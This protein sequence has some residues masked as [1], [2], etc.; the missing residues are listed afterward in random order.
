[1]K[2]GQR[3]EDALLYAV[4]LHATQERKGSG[5]PYSAHLL[6]TASIALEYG[7]DE[8][9]AV[10]ALLHDA[11]ED[12]GGPEQLETIRCKFGERVAGIVEGCTD[13]WQEPKPAWRPRKK[14]YLQS[15]AQ[16]DEDTL[17]VSCADKLYNARAILKDYRQVGE[18][19][20]GRFNAGKEGVLWYYRSLSEQYLK[21]F[22]G[23][24]AEELNNTV[25]AI[26]KI[27]T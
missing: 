13:S 25:N 4:H 1:M 10:A 23:P 27:V 6:G 9:Q 17:L 8:E 2:L 7:A 22:P 16:K 3:F 5:V 26:E 19:L 24:L 14:A 21:Y 12:Q 11:V 15:L 18:D 20:W